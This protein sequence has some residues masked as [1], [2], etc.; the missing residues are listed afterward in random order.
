M[1]NLYQAEEK[2]ENYR[3]RVPL[4]ET[5]L[6]E[7]FLSKVHHPVKLLRRFDRNI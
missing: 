6:T 5:D 4:E 7:V 1:L 2:P 3:K